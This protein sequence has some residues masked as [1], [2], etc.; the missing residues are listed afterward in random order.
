MF[1]RGIGYENVNW[2]KLTQ[3][4]FQ[5]WTSMNNVM[6]FWVPQNQEIAWCVNYHILKEGPYRKVI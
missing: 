2:I 6:R 4:R 3:D 1:R 5:R